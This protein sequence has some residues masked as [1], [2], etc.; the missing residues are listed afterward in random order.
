MIVWCLTPFS[1]E[2]QLYRGGQCTYPCSPGVLLTSTPH[3]ILSKPLAA[4][5]HN[6][7]R[8]NG[9]Q[10]KK[11][12]SC[13]NDYHQS[14]ERILAEPGIKPVISYSQA[15]LPI[16]LRGLRRLVRINTILQIYLNPFSQSM[17]H[18]SLL[19]EFAMLYLGGGRWFNPQARL[20]LFPR[21][22]DSRCDRIHSSFR[23]DH[24]S[25]MTML[26]SSQWLEKNI[27]LSAVK[28]SSRKAWGGAPFTAI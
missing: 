17:T 15:K 16:N 12:E 18:I 1:T 22:D 9:Q 14:W 13:R 7:C 6:H 23:V 19:K 28:K 24:F 20:I 8:N 25:A 3:S 5:P 11:S 26:E 27:V 4:F 2:F 10:R 21:I